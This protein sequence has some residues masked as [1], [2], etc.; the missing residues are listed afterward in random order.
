MAVVGMDFDAT[1]L[2]PVTFF[3]VLASVVVHGGS[4]AF[5]NLSL[6]RAS[7]YQPW[8]SMRSADGGAGAGGGP[9]SNAAAAEPRVTRL[10]SMFGGGTRTAGAATLRGHP[11]V[12]VGDANET[13]VYIMET[14]PP[15]LSTGYSP[16]MAG[17]AVAAATNVSGSYGKGGNSD[18]VLDTVTGMQEAEQA[19]DALPESAGEDAEPGMLGGDV[20]AAP[21]SDAATEASTVAGGLAET[22]PTAVAAAAA[23]VSREASTAAGTLSGGG[24]NI[25][26]RG[27]EGPAFLV[28][29]AQGSG[30]P[31]TETD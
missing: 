1:V 16:E 21:A 28:T 7:T 8:A 23:A 19:V 20:P 3:L 31:H 30:V 4:V 15:A 26:R 10:R 12:L 11:T 5:F 29:E 9:G 14:L 27:G 2:I 24:D 13:A 22:S 17:A 6:S 25:D 18:A